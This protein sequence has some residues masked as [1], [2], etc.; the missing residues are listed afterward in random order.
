[1]D[2]ETLAQLLEDYQLAKRRERASRADFASGWVAAR[3]RFA[4]RGG[5]NGEVLQEQTAA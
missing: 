4:E 5:V 3:R 1:M 2:S